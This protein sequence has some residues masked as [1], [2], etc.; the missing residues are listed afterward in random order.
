[1]P[2]ID[3]GAKQEILPTDVEFAEAVDEARALLGRR[4][5]KAP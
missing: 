2:L 1:M 3:L 5:L 4:L